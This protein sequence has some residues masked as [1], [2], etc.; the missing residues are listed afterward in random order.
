MKIQQA[1]FN[2]GQP[3]DSIGVTLKMLGYSLNS[4][5]QNELDEAKEMLIKQK[6]LLLAYVGDEVKDKMIGNEAALAVVWSGDAVYMMRENPDLDYVIPKEGSNIW[7][8]A[9]VIPKTSQN[10]KSSPKPLSI[11]CVLQILLIAMLTI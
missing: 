9:M 6:P 11:S 10:K 4:R 1:D 7:F 8:D 2:V 3:T 5:A